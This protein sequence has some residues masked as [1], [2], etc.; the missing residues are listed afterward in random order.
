[1]CVSESGVPVLSLPKHQLDDFGAMP[2]HFQQVA[3]GDPLK[4]PWSGAG[5]VLHNVANGRSF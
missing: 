1:M 2:Q 3:E 5:V 4:I